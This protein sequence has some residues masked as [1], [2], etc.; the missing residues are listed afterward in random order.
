[1][2]H[3]NYFPKLKTITLIEVL[4]SIAVFSYGILSISYLIISNINLSER[5]RLKTTA[6]MLAKEWIELV[7][8]RRDTNIKKW[9]LWN[10]LALDSNS[11]NG[12]CGLFFHNPSDT[13]SSTKRMIVNYPDEGYQFQ[14]I[15]NLSNIKLYKKKSTDGSFGI[16]TNFDAYGIVGTQSSAFSRTITFSPVYLEPEWSTQ[17]PD[18][19]LKVTSTVAYK[20]WSYSGSV[21]LQSFIGETLDSISLDE[22]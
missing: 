16:Y 15:I 9:W 6:T 18:K 21:S 11:Y 20:K 14:P 8:N 13:S 5:T 19:L 2:K 10:C 12:S 4:I 7:Y 3:T 17:H 1:M 22:Y